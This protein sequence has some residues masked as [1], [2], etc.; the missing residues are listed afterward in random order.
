MEASG[1]ASLLDIMINST[2]KL[3][4]SELDPYL[5]TYKALIGQCFPTIRVFSG[6]RLQQVASFR[7]TRSNH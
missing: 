1:E 2:S 6:I 4:S 7:K 3:D 5:R